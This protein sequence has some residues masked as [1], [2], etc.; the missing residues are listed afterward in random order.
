MRKSLAF[1]LVELLVVIGVISLLISI[2]M[3]ALNAAREQA[4]AV[5]CLSNLRQMTIAAHAYV[6]E[7]GGRYPVGYWGLDSW[8]FSI[9]PAGITPGLLWAGRGTTQ[10]Q[11]CPSFDGRSNTPSDPYTG[12]NYNIS[13]I[14]HGQF[15]TIQRPAKATQVRH[16]AS[17]ALFGDGE[18]AAGA[19]KYMRSPF[20]HPGDLSNSVRVG[21]AQGFRHRGKTNVA[22]CDGHAET[23]HERFTNTS[24]PN[25][26]APRTGFLS[27]DN[28]MYDLE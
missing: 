6:N 13:Y 11:Q 20:S 15:E 19:N 21:G 25:P 12:Y 4:R 18:Y 10:V 17:T 1:T 23:L 14:G 24:D 16:P 26:V 9:T 2:L 22:F 5:K 3:P 27:A 7:N 8:D 28:G